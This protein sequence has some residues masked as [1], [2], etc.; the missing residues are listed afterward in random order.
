[1]AYRQFAEEFDPRFKVFH[2]LM[3]SKVR[4]VLLVSTPYDAWS[5]EEEGRLAEELVR[6]YRGLNL[7]SPPRL[8]WASG[9]KEALAAMVN[10]EFDLAI[11]VSTGE[12]LDEQE[13][14][15][16]MRRIKPDLPVIHL[17]HHARPPRNNGASGISAARP[18]EHTFLWRGNR[19]LFVALIKSVED[20]LN[21]QHD[22]ELAGIRVIILV[23][24]SP[25]HL[26]TILPILYK[27]IV[28][29]TRALIDEGLNENHRLLAMRARPKILLASDFEKAMALYERYKPFVLGIISDVRF[30]RGGVPDLDA[31]IDLL[32]HVHADRFDIPLLLMSSEPRN[33]ARADKIPATFVDKNSPDLIIQ[34]RKFMLRHLGFGHFDFRDSSS[35]KIIE[36]AGTLRELGRCLERIP[37]DSFLEHCRHNDFSRWL[38]ARAEI[39]LADKLR[40]LRYEDFVSTANHREA[41]ADLILERLRQR[42]R[43]LVI[44]FE[45]RSFDDDFE[46]LK[47]GGGSMGGKGRGL[48]F[49]AAT[50]LADPQLHRDFPD[51]E[52]LIPPALILDTELFEEFIQRNRLSHLASGKYEDAE[53]DRR[54]LKGHISK[55]LKK[56]LRTFLDKVSYPLAIRSSGLLEDGYFAAYAGLY[57]T[58]MLSNDEADPNVRLNR[59]LDAVRLVYAS[60]YRKDARAFAQ[61]VGHR[62][63]E[64]GM[65]VIIQK[66]AG[67]DHGEWFHPAV[68]G[69]AQSVNYYPFGRM[70][71]ED[72]V[73]TIA[74]GLGTMVVQGGKS[75]RFS[76][77][78]P[79]L[80]PEHASVQ[81]VLNSAQQQFYSLRL[82]DADPSRQGDP[83][84]TLVL[85]NLNEVIE[86][87]PF[88][89]LVSTY[90]PG[91]GR[92]RDTTDVPG[93]RVMNFTPL[94]KYGVVDLPGILHE[95]LKRCRKGMGCPV[96]LEFALDL[97]TKP[98]ERAKFHI[99]QLRPMSARQEHQRVTI[100]KTDLA[101]AIC[102]AS[103]A[104]GNG[105]LDGIGDVVFIDPE[106]FDPANTREIAGILGEFNA[107]L[108]EEGRRY[109]LIGPG[110][111]GSSDPWLGIPVDWQQI[112]AVAAIIE[113]RHEKLTA[114]P[115]QGSHFFHNLTTLGIPHLSQAADDHIDW[116]WFR[117]QPRVAES[118][119][120]VR[121]SPEC[122]IQ[123][124]VDGRGGRGV[125]RVMSIQS[126]EAEGG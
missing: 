111:W 122:Q 79:E 64:E 115:S 49:V 51:L 40:P 63:A 6:E 93:V 17:L 25:E 98:G 76:P 55:T 58:V 52:I 28:A 91:E 2:E 44:E 45:A 43:G 113:T 105:I 83:S 95:I 80:Q 67:Q 20:E 60:T 114:E 18:L 16:E 82:N 77:R 104:Q 22:T 89:R 41:L 75:W 27:E 59:L 50:I 99:L 19:D 46:L 85:R 81:D 32:C 87:E 109:L 73:A 88:R 8:R 69:V 90:V 84:D 54:F 48:A 74:A 126:P 117:S 112:S 78:A 53:I 15:D 7:S 62:V 24:D 72:G 4:E 120:V 70:K 61:R 23:E 56:Q 26:S 30:P 42:Q 38:Y 13:C 107:R 92:I 118:G 5:M 102:T 35:G 124:K 11:L 10:D 94:L 110:R 12:C 116:D 108:T 37:E 39:E 31:G 9:Q 14:T 100:S 96:E 65:A 36:R 29:Q 86:A 123:L 66:L 57:R 33:A 125:L 119:G 103:Y 97:P 3:R 106:G 68:S 121:V 71:A 21:A 101:N 1:M 47:I 34:V